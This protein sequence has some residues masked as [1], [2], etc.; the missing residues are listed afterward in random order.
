VY[1]TPS[2]TGP[3]LDDRPAA[4]GKL[5]EKLNELAQYLLDSLFLD[6]EGEVNTEN[7]RALLRKDESPLSRALL[8]K[9]IDEDGID[10]LLI[11]LTE[12]LT[13]N[14]PTGID[15]KVIREHL[16]SYSES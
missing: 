3:E 16:T 4:G 12:V 14:L 15:Q 11:T 10:D 9:I 7:V 13:E 5:E 2:G 8:Q 6:F 1:T